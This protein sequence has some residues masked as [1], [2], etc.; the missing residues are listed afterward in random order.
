MTLKDFKDKFS[1]WNTYY[2][3]NEVEKMPWYEKNLDNDLENEI[4]S[5]NLSKG[6]FLD[7]GTGPG[8]QANQL[9]KRGFDVTGTDLSENA[10][11]KAK[12]LSNKV[13]FLTDDFL[14]SKLPDNEFEIGR[15]S[16]R[17]RV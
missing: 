16:C 12:T 5:R 17:E 11:D 3:D 1:D 7:L 8:T 10:I 9:A 4:I 14:N 6:R 15:A 13:N 2:N